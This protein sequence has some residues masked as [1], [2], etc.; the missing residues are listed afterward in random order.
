MTSKAFI[1]MKRECF[2]EVTV[3]GFGHQSRVMEGRTRGQLEWLMP[4]ELRRA[5][6]CKVRVRSEVS[7]ASGDTFMEAQKVI[8][9]I[10]FPEFLVLRDSQ[11]NL[12]VRDLILRIRWGKRRMPLRQKN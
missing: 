2:A 5:H 1:S 7:V 12:G 4:R 8:G 6:G 10:L 9:M 3:A 11:A